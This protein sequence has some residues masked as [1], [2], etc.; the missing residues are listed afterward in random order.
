M[1]NALEQIIAQYQEL[2]AVKNV[3][4]D[5]IFLRKGVSAPIQKIAKMEKTILVYV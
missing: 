2:L 5:I 3:F 4:Q 1:E